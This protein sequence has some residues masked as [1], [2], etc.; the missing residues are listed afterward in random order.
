MTEV[1]RDDEIRLGVSEVGLQYSGDPLAEGFGQM[2]NEDRHQLQLGLS[3]TISSDPS[4]RWAE[5]VRWGRRRTAQRYVE[6]T[7]GAFP[8]Y[9]RP[10][11]YAPPF[12]QTDRSDS[13]R[14]W[15]KIDFISVRSLLL[16][17]W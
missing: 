11:P 10:R 8:N 5:R 2:P 12:S 16:T 1:R 13:A 4:G 17:G 15:L 14:R 3:E 9:A 7:A 6:C